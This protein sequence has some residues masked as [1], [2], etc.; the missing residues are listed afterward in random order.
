MATQVDA[1]YIIKRPMLTE[2][3]TIGMSELNTYTFLVDRTA[4]KDQI[5]SAIE[6][7]YK[8]KVASVRTSLSKGKTKRTKFGYSTDAQTKKALVRVAEGQAI[9]MI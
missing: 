2:K 9:E 8:V 6:S 1:T 5:K 4:S 3:S 7:L